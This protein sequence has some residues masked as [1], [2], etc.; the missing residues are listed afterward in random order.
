[1]DKIMKKALKIR[2]WDKAP[3]IKLNTAPAIKMQDY[4]R[5]V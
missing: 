5:M 3:R 2:L 4:K 1:M